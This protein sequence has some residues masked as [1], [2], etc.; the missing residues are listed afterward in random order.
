MET[1]LHQM[2]RN[3]H[4][5][6]RSGACTRFCLLAIQI[7]PPG[8]PGRYP[9]L[10]YA[11]VTKLQQ[12][13]R[14]FVHKEYATAISLA[15]EHAH[16]CPEDT[17]DAYVLVAQAYERGPSSFLP[18]PTEMPG[19]FK[20][21]SRPDRRNAEYYYRLAISIAPR[22]VGALRRIVDYLPDKSEERREFLERSVEVQPG[23]IPLI[24]LGDYFR[25]I[26]KNLE[27]AYSLYCQAHQLEPKDGT[28]YQHLNDI[29][30]RLGRPDEARDW[31]QKWR[32]AKDGRSNVGRT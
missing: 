27:R 13:N 17:A 30:R 20:L 23:T 31:S 7:S 19:Q 4:G 2:E 18:V 29:C 8:K 9:T 24:D 32:D 26:E 22:H 5:L 6:F 1:R 10:V 11:S 15:L 28:A 16:E 21:V 12:A 14:A 25:S 3:N